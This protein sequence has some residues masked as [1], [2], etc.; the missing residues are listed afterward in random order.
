MGQRFLA[1]P[2]VVEEGGELAAY[3]GMGVVFVVK[4]FLK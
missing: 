2:M 1:V 3:V 4:R